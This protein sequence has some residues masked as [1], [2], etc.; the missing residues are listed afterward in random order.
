MG[1]YFT[2]IVTNKRRGTLY[3]GMT[4]TIS[5]RSL[6][7]KKSF[8]ANSFTDKYNLKRL[9]WYESFSTPSGAIRREKEIKGWT[10]EKKIALIE[11]S[12]PEWKDLYGELYRKI[13][14]K[15]RKMS[16]VWNIKKEDKK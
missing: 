16:D 4:N 7:H 3:T 10:R 5:K 15:Y 12:N 2:Y 6:R 13:H 8:N 9:V 14:S 11:K 1:K